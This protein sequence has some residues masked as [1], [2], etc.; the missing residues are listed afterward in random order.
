MRPDG[1]LPLPG[2]VILPALES[3]VVVCLSSGSRSAHGGK[4][5]S[6]NDCPDP[7]GLTQ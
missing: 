6:S 5:V 1:L 4:L 2:E 7:E 3:E